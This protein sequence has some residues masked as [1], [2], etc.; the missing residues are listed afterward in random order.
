[1]VNVKVSYKYGPQ[2]KSAV[3]NSSTILSAESKTESAVMAALKKKFPNKELMIL[4]IE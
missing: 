3:S 1:M 2:G 4:K